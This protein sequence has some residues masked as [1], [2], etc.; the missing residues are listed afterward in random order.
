MLS[1]RASAALQCALLYAL[2]RTGCAVVQ[3]TLLLWKA[4]AKVETSCTGEELTHM[5]ACSVGA[6][7]T[8][9]HQNLCL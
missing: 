7:N 3:C 8:C 4:S 6:H 9:L 2:E 1:L 5:R